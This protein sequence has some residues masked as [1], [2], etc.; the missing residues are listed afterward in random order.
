MYLLWP[1][2]ASCDLA[3]HYVTWVHPSHLS[4]RFGSLRFQPLPITASMQ[5]GKI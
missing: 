3:L 1:Y 4:S 2:L 5:P